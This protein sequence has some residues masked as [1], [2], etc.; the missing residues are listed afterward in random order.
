MPSRAVDDDKEVL[1]LTIS[2]ESYL[3]DTVVR[4]LPQTRL[5]ALRHRK[6]QRLRSE[7]LELDTPPF[8][9]ENTNLG[10]EIAGAIWWN[11]FPLNFC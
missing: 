9:Q 10:Y 5:V 2:A 4:I 7:S 1:P 3:A 11:S 6:N 8:E